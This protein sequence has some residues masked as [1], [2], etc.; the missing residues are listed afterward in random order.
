MKK[1]GVLSPVFGALLLAAPACRDLSEG[2]GTGGRV[3]VA[4]WLSLLF[5]RVFWKAF[6]APLFL[7]A[8]WVWIASLA[9]IVFYLSGIFPFWAFALGLLL[10]ERFRERQNPPAWK[11]CWTEGPAVWTGCVLMGSVAEG[12]F[13][14]APSAGGVAAG[15]FFAL[16]LTALAVRSRKEAAS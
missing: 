4:F 2:Y 9:Q 13:R 10:T 8:L 11:I 3:C 5:F 1:E 14:G 15:I 6:P 7:F 16:G 12:L